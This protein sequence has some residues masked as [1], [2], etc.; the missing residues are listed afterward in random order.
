MSALKNFLKEHKESRSLRSKQPAHDEQEVFRIFF[1]RYQSKLHAYIQRI[2][3][4]PEI[5]EELVTDIFVKIWS[6]KEMLDNVEN[7]DAF[8]YRMAVNKALDFMRIASREKKLRLLLQEFIQ[9]ENSKT[10]RQYELKEYQEQVDYCMQLL[11]D[12]QRVILNLSREEGLTHK[13]IAEE[14]QLSQHTVKNHI[15]NALKQMRSFLKN[16]TL[17]MLLAIKIIFS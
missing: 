7:V 16:G 4:S 3:K 12:Q 9:R 8:L 13:Q 2:V 10:Y 17:L 6:A 15:V 1:L 5:T 11:T 14:L